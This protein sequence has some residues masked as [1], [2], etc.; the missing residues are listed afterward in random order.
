MLFHAPQLSQRPA[1]FGLTA[2]QVWQTWREVSLAKSPQ[3]EW[4]VSIAWPRC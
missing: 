1:H 4:A 3:S 2:P